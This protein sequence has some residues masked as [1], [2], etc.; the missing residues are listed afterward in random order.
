MQH[1]GNVHVYESAKQAR[2]PID[3][4]DITVAFYWE[5]GSGGKGCIARDLASL[6]GRVTCS[7][8]A[9]QLSLD[10]SWIDKLPTPPF[11]S[12]LEGNEEGKNAT[13][14]LLRRDVIVESHA[15]ESQLRHDVYR[16]SKNKV[17]S[18]I[19]E[20]AGWRR[21]PLFRRVCGNRYKEMCINRINKKLK[22]R[23]IIM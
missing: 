15:I 3:R 23:K 20:E 7:S 5:E 1:T 14:C 22:T 13:R 18:A 19:K 17:F 11:R 12:R 2:S 10:N 9:R 8:E 16:K 4:C 6:V 21:V